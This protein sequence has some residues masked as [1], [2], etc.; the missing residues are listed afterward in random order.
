MSH[1]PVYRLVINFQPN[2]NQSNI[3]SR[4][5][6]RRQRK[7]RF[8]NSMKYIH[9]SNTVSSD[10][11]YLIYINLLKQN[12]R[13]VF[14]MQINKDILL[15]SS[16]WCCIQLSFVVLLLLW[17]ELC[18]NPPSSLCAVMKTKGDIH[19]AKPSTKFSKCDG[20]WVYSFIYNSFK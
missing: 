18:Q 7:H 9:I 19:I 20:H 14:F 8:P 4:V 11:F 1:G 3:L 16:W 6:I 5:K 12:V 15:M 10:I 13:F 2:L 17:Y